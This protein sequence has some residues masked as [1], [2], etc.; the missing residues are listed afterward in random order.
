MSM[1][2]GM[3]WVMAMMASVLMIFAGIVALLTL[4][5]SE[6]APLGWLFVVVGGLLL[7]ANLAI[8]RRPL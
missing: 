2:S 4:A 3:G 8:R 7:V 5:D 1:A 6:L